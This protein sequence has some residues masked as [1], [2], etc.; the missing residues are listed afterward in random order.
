MNGPS[1]IDLRIQSEYP[2]NVTW[3]WRTRSKT[4]ASDEQKARVAHVR[5]ARGIH[6][7]RPG[8]ARREFLSRQDIETE[9]PAAQ[10]RTH[11]L[12]GQRVE[13]RSLADVEKTIDIDDD[14][15]VSTQAGRDQLKGALDALVHQFFSLEIAAYAVGAGQGEIFIGNQRLSRALTRAAQT[16]TEIGRQFN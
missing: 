13:Y 11:R 16:Q 4:A 2:R 6:R 15:V 9:S 10:P 3:P 1:M 14:Q 5:D 12:S 8:R 7:P